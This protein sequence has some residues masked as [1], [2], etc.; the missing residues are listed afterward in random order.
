MLADATRV[1]A[2]R[3][4]RLGLGAL[5]M[6]LT[7]SCGIDTIVYLS[8]KAERRSYDPPSSFVLSGPST[9]DAS[10]LGLNV[11]YRIY[12]VETDATADVNSISARQS[13][14]NAVPGASVPGYLASSSGL[15]YQRLVLVDAATGLPVDSIPTLERSLVPGDGL[16]AVTFNPSGEPDMEIRLGSAQAIS[17]RYLLRRVVTGGSYGN[18][19]FIDPPVA[20]AVDYKSGTVS[21][22]RYY[23]QFFAAAYGMNFD[24]FEELYGDA[25]HLGMITIDL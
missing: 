14:T 19:R 1:K 16:V 23:I 22:N 20:G 13:A 17:R 6:T 12:A 11:Y 10:Y 4:R 5:L 24:T 25:V 7:V 8:L 21:S 2:R 9:S 3:L 15:G 18:L